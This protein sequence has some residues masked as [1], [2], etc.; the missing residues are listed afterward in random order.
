MTTPT[1]NTPDKIDLMPVP[2]SIKFQGGA[3]RVSGTF[4]TAV[5]GYV[6]DRLRNAI[7]R[8]TSRLAGRTVLSLT[9]DLATDESAATL[10]IQCD[11][12]GE[13]IPS[14]TENE[15][16]KLEITDRQARL[17]APTVVGALRGMETILQLLQA[18]RD[19][20]FLPGV[21]IQDQPRFPWR[22]LLI[23]VG[24][25]FEPMEVLKRNLDAMAAVKLNV[26][27]WHLTEDQGF[28]VESKKLPR[29]HSM[30]SDGLYYT[31]DQVRE[32]IGYA[33]ERG[34]RVMPE[35]DIPGHST[36]WLVGHPEV[37][38][39]PG[40]YK[41]ERGAG[42][43][44]PALDPT[45][46]QTYK[47][48]EAFLGEMAALF[49]D[50]Y[51]HIGGDE[52]EGKQWD[53]NPKIQSFMKEKG[54]KDNH[55][56]QAYFNQRLLKIL[57]KHGKKMIGWDEILHDDLP[58]DAMIQSWRG[59][60][61]LADAARKGYNGILSA[62]YYIDLIFPA[63]EHYSVDPLPE[64]STLTVE[65]AKRVLGGEATMWGEWV[66]PE[67]IDSRIWPRTAAIAERLW[68]PRNVTD[69]TDMYRR[70]AI[71]SRQLEELGLTHKKN[72]TTMLRRLAASDNIGPLATLASTLEPVKEYRRY[73]QRPQTMLS[74]LT[75]LIDATPPDSELG[76]HF[77]GFVDGFLSDAPRFA[78]YRH[79]ID[80][81]FIDWRAASIA[82]G[83][84]IDQS[85]SLQEVKPLAVELGEI[86][87]A[88]MEAMSYLSAGNSA[89]TEWR[90]AQL[91]RLDAAAKPKG[92]L[93]SVVTLNVRK[94]VIAAA[95]LPSLKSLS[96]QDWKKRVIDLASPVKK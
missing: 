64:T 21:S 67:T 92:G 34:I 5:K 20:Y 4:S 32:I 6:D 11:G 37:G 73:Q 87:E 33:R 35:F 70:L 84:V 79:E 2:A 30:G 24:R 53:R 50:A 90:D 15:S 62:G 3:L 42:I 68:S 54:I 13:T 39:A 63:S 83:P 9:Y 93:E 27:H 38:S 45:N 75:G 12:A 91:T 18:D 1:A 80:H 81:V 85:P 58:R 47:L 25:H 19:G 44:E 26:L 46:E 65:E 17:Q 66:S 7:A 95:E 61:S 28:R 77:A 40:P 43:F 60:G 71:I 89:T 22:G 96:L 49:P 16:Y 69:V 41:I 78:L 51:L 74:P 31:Q 48:L 82:L 76:R 88:G 14:V 36:S 94:L 57:Q 29:L 52:N 56:L 86:A 23:D 55:A 10:V 72:V 59:P 8:M